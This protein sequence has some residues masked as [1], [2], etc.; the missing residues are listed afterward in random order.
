MGY[1][2]DK[3]ELLQEVVDLRFVNEEL[4]KQIAVSLRDIVCKSIV[5]VLQSCITNPFL[6]LHA[7]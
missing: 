3:N 4:S 2:R 5:L 1:I 6:K 7:H